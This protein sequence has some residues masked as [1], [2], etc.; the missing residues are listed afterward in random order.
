MC[1]LDCSSY[2]DAY[3]IY[4]ISPTSCLCGEGRLWNA[5]LKVCGK[6]CTAGEEVYGKLDGLIG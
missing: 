6:N 1:V 2:P 4:G 5:D 3:D